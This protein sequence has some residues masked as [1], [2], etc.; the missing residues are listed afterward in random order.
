MNET[1]ITLTLSEFGFLNAL[2]VD[3]RN[4]LKFEEERIEGRFKVEQNQYQTAI[5]K[6]LLEKLNS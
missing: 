2:L 1:N 6:S 3:K 5:V 4:K